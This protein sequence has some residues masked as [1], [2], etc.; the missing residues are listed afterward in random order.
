MNEQGQTQTGEGNQGA[1]A[2]GQAGT[3]N[4][5]AQTPGQTPEIPEDLQNVAVK[6]NDGKYFV[7]LD[8][9]KDERTKR[10][11]AEQSLNQAKDQ[12]FLYQM[13][14]PQA[15]PHGNQGGAAGQQAGTDTGSGEP[16]KLPDWLDGM[17]DDEVIN[18]SEL[19][20]I[21]KGLNIS[22][23]AGGNDPN[24]ALVGE[25]LLTFIKPDAET[26]I[27]G[28][29]AQRLRNEP[30]LR[31]FIMR[32]PPLLRP[33][34]AYRLGKGQSFHDAASGATQDVKNA[35]AGVTQGQQGPGRSSADQVLANAA[36][37]SPTATITGAGALDMAARYA[38]M[39]DDEIEAEI[40]R[41]KEGV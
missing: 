1:A 18:A 31:D 33:F 17:E 7:P 4:Q 19:K 24:M 5:G 38:K 2:P 28:G 13:N 22:R 21:V 40:A 3:Q 41:V 27:S 10:Q 26:V 29:F 37:P 25:Q 23:G 8:A 39:T 34:T 30:Y 12:L 11:T 16:I 14:P 32:V 35:P 9:L 15:G 20:K 6:G 36:K